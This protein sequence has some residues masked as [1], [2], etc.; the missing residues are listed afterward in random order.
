[1]GFNGMCYGISERML[2][3]IG[4]TSGPFKAPRTQLSH[5]SS[6]LPKMIAIG[7]SLGTVCDGLLTEM[8]PLQRGVTPQT[9]RNKVCET[10]AGY[11]YYT[12]TNVNRPIISTIS[13]LGL[14]H[15]VILGLTFGSTSSSN[16][17]QPLRIKRR[18]RKPTC[19]VLV[20][21]TTGVK[22]LFLFKIH[23][24]LHSDHL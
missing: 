20:G 13:L 23:Q 9:C 22:F 12:L 4:G 14:H 3:Q 17:A 15:L 21:N 6:D 19:R 1:M 8:S 24:P 7:S 10:T 16:M 11:V 18:L 2:T 5:L